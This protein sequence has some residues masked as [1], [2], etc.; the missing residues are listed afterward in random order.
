MPLVPGRHQ[1]L[2]ISALSV[3]AV[4]FLLAS[5][6]TPSLAATR[7]SDADTFTL[8]AQ[9]NDVIGSGKLS[10]AVSVR[11]DVPAKDLRVEVTL[12]PKLEN[13]SEFNSTIQNLEPAGNSCLSRDRPDDPD[14]E[15][16]RC[17]RHHPL[18]THG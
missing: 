15:L 11:A 6:T 1:V 9:S 12:F 16:R 17:R 2:R 7:S 13:R 4:L 10:L 3:G 14:E 8:V 18:Q 5:L